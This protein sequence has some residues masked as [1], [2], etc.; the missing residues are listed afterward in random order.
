MKLNDQPMSM[1][2]EYLVATNDF[3]AAGGDEYTS[4]KSSPTENE[5]PALDEVLISFIQKQGT[6]NYS[7]E[8]RITEEQKSTPVVYWDE[9]VLKKG[10][11]GRISVTKP[12]NLWK[13]E[14]DKLI[15]VKVLK[16]GQTFRVYNYD[17]KYF[18]QYG[19]GAGHYIT[20]M[21]GY[22]KYETPSKAKLAAVNN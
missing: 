4:F 13:R 16:P 1:T 14:G 6:V 7:V 3:L 8:K 10:Q 22:I 2:K 15:F 19:V 20:N 17:S 5:F 9:A 12:I 11:I 18:G 21:K